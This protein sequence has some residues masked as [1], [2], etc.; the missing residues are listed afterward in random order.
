M[1][2]V[3]KLIA[4]LESAANEGAVIENVTAL[5][6]SFERESDPLIQAACHELRH[7]LIDED[8][9]ARDKEY[10]LLQRKKLRDYVLRM[11]KLFP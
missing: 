5:L 3:K 8:I 4:L 2:D 9:R 11:K 1:H 6:S 10:D 7:F